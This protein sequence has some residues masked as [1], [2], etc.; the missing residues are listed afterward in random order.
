MGYI[1]ICDFWCRRH[2]LLL[3]DCWHFWSKIR[4]VFYRDSA[5]CKYTP[6]K[7]N[8]QYRG[9]N[10]TDN[11]MLLN[12]KLISKQI[13]WILTEFG[14]YPWQLYIA[15]VL[16]GLGSG[17]AF[18]L[19]PLYVSEICEPQWVLMRFVHAINDTSQSRQMNKSCSTV[20]VVVWAHWWCCA[21]MPGF[22]YRLLLGITCSII[23]S[24]TLV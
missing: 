24:H 20:F 10:M 17:G 15:R 14:V 9:D 18:S 8:H 13:C 1:V 4:F 3:L 6:T 11:V 12:L 5:C 23:R 21:Q 22:W 19:V 7:W 16:S 2:L